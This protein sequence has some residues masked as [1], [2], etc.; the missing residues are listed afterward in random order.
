MNDGV[1]KKSLE[2]LHWFHQYV[3]ILFDILYDIQNSS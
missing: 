3:V 1:S 2:T